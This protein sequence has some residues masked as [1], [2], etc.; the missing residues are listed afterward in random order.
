MKKLLLLILTGA[1]LS[2]QAQNLPNIFNKKKPSADTAKKTGGL[3]EQ[4]KG[5]LGNASGGNLSNVDISNGLKEALSVGAERTVQQLSKVD[6]FLGN[7]ALKI[8]LPP[9]AQVIE[10]KLRAIGMGKQIDEAIVSLNRAAEDAATSAAPIFI[11]AIKNITLQDAMGILKG[12]DTAATGYLKQN[13]LQPI[14]N[15]FTPIITQSL[16]KVN[17]TKH[18]STIINAYNKISFKKV[19]PN[20]AS[21]VTERATDGLFKQICEEEKKIR[22]NPAARSTALLQKVFS[23]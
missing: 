7:A 5:I 3:L 22:Q 15:A 20:L 12:A 10:Q 4:A 23:K 19:N 2:T 8:L 16:D 17:A 6:G 21:Y 1:V 11:N 9:E 18:W 13:T 14:T